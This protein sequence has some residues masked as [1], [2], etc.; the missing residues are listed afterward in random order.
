MITLKEARE[1]T[2]KYLDDHIDAIMND[3]FVEIRKA[4]ERGDS[5][6]IVWENNKE[7][8]KLIVKK[9]RKA[10]F[11]ARRVIRDWEETTRVYISWK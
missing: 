3:I 4:S 5:E 2:K 8:R 6:I 10:G 7:M 1:N 11:D 9:C